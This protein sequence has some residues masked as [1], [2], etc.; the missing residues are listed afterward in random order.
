M[1]KITEKKLPKIR[2]THKEIITEGMLNPDTGITADILMPV[3]CAKTLRRRPTRDNLTAI[4]T[5]QLTTKT[6]LST[7]GAITDEIST[8][9]SME[10]LNNIIRKIMH[11]EINI[12]IGIKDRQNH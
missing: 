3:Q 5:D 7:E 8:R 10:I 4:T 6:G 11:I 12:G 1:R 2:Q 9:T